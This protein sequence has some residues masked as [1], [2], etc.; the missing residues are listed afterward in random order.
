MCCCRALWV[1]LAQED[2]GKENHSTLSSLLHFLFNL[3]PN[4]SGFS[5]RDEDK[6]RFNIST[7]GGKGSWILKLWLRRSYSILCLLA[8]VIINT[9]QGHIW[10]AF[11]ITLK[12]WHKISFS[13]SILWTIGGKLCSLYCTGNSEK[14]VLKMKFLLNKFPCSPLKGEHSTWFRILRFSMSSHLKAFFKPY[15]CSLK[16]TSLSTCLGELP[17]SNVASP[18]TLWEKGQE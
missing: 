13:E 7:G 1:K 17:W 15:L 5:F 4:R 16:C 6:R 10:D 14:V 9:T 3:L 12:A 11:Q 2:N 8:S 18:W